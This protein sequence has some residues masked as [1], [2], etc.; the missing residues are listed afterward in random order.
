[1]NQSGAKFLAA[2]MRGDSLAPTVQF[3]HSVRALAAPSE[4][5]GAVLLD[6]ADELLAVQD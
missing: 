5:D 4:L 6:M 3:E 2:A 1:V